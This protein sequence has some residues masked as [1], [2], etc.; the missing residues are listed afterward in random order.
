MFGSNIDIREDMCISHYS[1][2]ML[3]AKFDL[4]QLGLDEI[5]L[6]KMKNFCEWLHPQIASYSNEIFN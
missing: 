6:N 3:F 1:L 4:F 5:G 2:L